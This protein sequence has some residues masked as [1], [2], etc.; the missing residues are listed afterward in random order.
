MARQ[1]I[2]D[3]LGVPVQTV[4]RWLEDLSQNGNLADSGK[5]LA[6]HLDELPG[7]PLRRVSRF[8]A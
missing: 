5:V 3:A 8:I 4:N 2:E 1:E 7:S 6:D